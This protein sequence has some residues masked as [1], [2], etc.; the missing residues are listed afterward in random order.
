MHIEELKF[1]LKNQKVSCKDY[2]FYIREK[3]LYMET[4]LN[5]LNKKYILSL[6][7]IIYISSLKKKIKLFIFLFIPPFILKKLKDNFS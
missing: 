5:I 4:M 2:F 1:W 3:I 6:K 7:N